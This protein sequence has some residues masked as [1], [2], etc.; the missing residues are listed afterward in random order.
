MQ[1][2]AKEIKVVKKI[3]HNEYMLAKAT[4]WIALSLFGTVDKWNLSSVYYCGGIIYNISALSVILKH[5]FMKKKT[6]QLTFSVNLPVCSRKIFYWANETKKM[7]LSS[8]SRVKIGHS[9]FS[10][11]FNS[12]RS[13]ML[14]IKYILILSNYLLGNV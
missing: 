13:S 7:G 2:K 4:D 11:S 10:L 1:W 8:S 14:F 9:A 12:S 6:M 3:S 5:I